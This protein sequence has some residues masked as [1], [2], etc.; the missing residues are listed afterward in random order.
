MS[1]FDYITAMQQDD[2]SMGANDLI[3]ACEQQINKLRLSV[4]GMTAE[5]LL[6]RPIP[7]KWSTLEVV[8]HIA[9][10]EI[11]LTDRIAR[12]LALDRPLLIGV[13]ERPYPERLN[14]QSFDVNE[15]LDLFTALRRHVV[16][17]LRGQTSAAWQRTAIHSESGVVNVRQLVFH[18][19]R[20]VQHHLKFIAE[21]RN[22][23]P[24]HP[25]ETKELMAMGNTIDDSSLKK[26]R[27]SSGTPWEPVVG[28]SR[29]IRMGSFVSVSG[30][31]AM[32]PDGKIVGIGDPYAQTV[33]ILKNIRSALNQLGASLDDVVR[34]R[35]YVVNIDHWEL[36]GKAHGEFFREVRPA[37]TMVEVRRL[38]SPDIEIEIEADAILREPIVGQQDQFS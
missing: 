28:Y 24:G 37:T 18:A 31:T 1:A 15:Q 21:K 19:I 30:T 2:E 9:D 32:G 3:H 14:Y 36:I 7:G 33:Q 13:D 34:T 8:S 29:A 10:T 16:R 27:Y 17:I 25:P 26:Q 12:A 38:I 35:M 4:R 22:A 5:E 20:H 11:Y 23:L 6:S